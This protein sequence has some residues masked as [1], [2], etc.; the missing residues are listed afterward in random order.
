[1]GLS[2]KMSDQWIPPTWEWASL[3]DIVDPVRD[4]VEPKQFPER[5]YNYL[6]IENIESN[7]G[8][9]VNFAPT[10]GKKIRSAK[11]VFT[12][13]D[14]L[15]SKLRP[16]LNKVFLPAFDGIS[17]TDLL[18][19]RPREG[20]S[21]EFVA[22][23]L[24][25]RKVVEFAN[26][27]M[28]GIQL[29]RL[30]VED[31]LSIRVPV[32]PSAEQIRIMNRIEELRRELR[33]ARQAL[34]KVPPIMRQFRLAVLSKALRGELTGSSRDGQ[35]EAG[36][37]ASSETP[38]GLPERWSWTKIGSLLKDSRYGTSQKSGGD[39]AGTPVLRIPNVVKGNIDLTD[40]KF[41]HFTEAEIARLRMELGDVLV[42][43]T[44]GSL[45][46]VGRSAV[47]P[48]LESDFV[49]ASYLIRLRPSVKG[50]LPE[51]LSFVLASP[52]GRKVI[53]ERARTTAGQYN[54]NLET[55]KSI[56]VPL[57]PPQEMDVIVRLLREELAR[58]EEIE[59][60]SLSG[61]GLTDT[62]EQ[63]ILQKAFR[64]GLVA[65]DSNDEPASVLLERIESTEPTAKKR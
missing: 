12:R 28:R 56:P 10:L 35:K 22:Y 15:Y 36:S 7:T 65:Q 57:P 24:R 11:L 14:L 60:S 40:L 45:D 43:R 34:Q 38:Y 58:S 6:S 23:F 51:Y 13:N 49:F 25:T 53:E 32:P 47:V 54:V 62:I 52:L 64:G 26:Q 48:E 63:S 44:N 61:L 29:P 37:D 17:A 46:L 55:L 4:H 39:S 5:E 59:Q 1:M 16:Y 20:I 27:R 50:A 41:G 33:I 21:R 18:P 19:I 2:L 8:N 9:P 31:L 30:A 42:C 3:G